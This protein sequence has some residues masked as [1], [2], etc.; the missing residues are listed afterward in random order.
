[1]NSLIKTP[2]ELLLEQAGLPS[3]A[4]GHSVSPEQ[5]RV[6]LMINGHKVHQEDLPHD[7]P[8][9]QHLA[10]GGEPEQPSGILAALDKYYHSLIPAGVRKVGERYFPILGGLSEASTIPANIASK[11]YVDAAGSATNAAAWLLPKVSH[12]LFPAAQGIEA[13]KNYYEGNPIEGH[14]NL[15]GA[16]AMMAAPE[17]T[18]PIMAAQYLMDQPNDMP[19][20]L[21]ASRS[22]SPQ[23]LKNID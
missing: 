3:F 1:M 16:A 23:D 2:Q 22:V 6:E 12:I 21:A 20:A 15:L 17:A 18:V 9:I 8:L 7:H 19:A 14:K 5:M 11:H 13:A 10:G 4:E